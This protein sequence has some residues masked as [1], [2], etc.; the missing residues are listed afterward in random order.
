MLEAF[1]ADGGIGVRGTRYRST[2]SLWLP[3]FLLKVCAL[4]LRSL[5]NGLSWLMRFDQHPCLSDQKV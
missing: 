5:S 4:I 2:G 3:F 1:A